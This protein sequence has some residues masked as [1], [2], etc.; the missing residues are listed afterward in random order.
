[1]N[2]VPHR[3]PVRVVTLWGYLHHYQKTVLDGTLQYVKFGVSYGGSI[4]PEEVVYYSHR[5]V[6]HRSLS[7][8]NNSLSVTSRERSAGEG[9]WR[10]CQVPLGALVI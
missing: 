3:R 6:L 2:E 5:F 9:G 1:M 7:L 10:L 4:S 8:S